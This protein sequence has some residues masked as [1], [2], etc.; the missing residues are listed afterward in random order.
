MEHSD[1]TLEYDQ[2]SPMSDKGDSAEFRSLSKVEPILEFLYRHW[3]RVEFLG[4]ERIPAH[5]EGPCLIVGNQGSVFPWP[6]LMLGHALANRKQ[7]ARRLYVLA[8]L[9]SDLDERVRTLLEGLG[10]LDWSSANMKTLFERGEAVAIFPEGISGLTKPFSRRYRLEDFD[11][12]MLLPVVESGVE[13]YPVSALGF[14][15]INPMLDNFEVLSKLLKMPFYPVTPFFPWL[16]MPLNLVQ[17]PVEVSM[18]V[19][20]KADYDK[21]KSRDDM[22]SVAKKL[23]FMLEGEIQAELN[24]MLRHRGL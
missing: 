7:G 14:D 23:S 9:E 4:L 5:S 21:V 24:R 16:P 8:D 20:K 22:E 17:L 18:N 3:W 11:W 2:D 6:A 12:T 10:F 19:L 1:L 15:E 13:V